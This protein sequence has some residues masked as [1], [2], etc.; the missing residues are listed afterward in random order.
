MF[1]DMGCTGDM[2]ALLWKLMTHIVSGR[3]CHL[4]AAWS[5]CRGVYL[6]HLQLEEIT[7]A[8]LESQLGRCRQWHDSKLWLY[9]SMLHLLC[10]S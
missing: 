9:D 5:V 4:A 10:K 3:I 7:S 1:L 8:K 6:V 2:K